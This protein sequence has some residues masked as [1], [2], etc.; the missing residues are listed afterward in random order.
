MHSNPRHNPYITFNY[1]V[2]HNVVVCYN[3]KAYYSF[4]DE[5]LI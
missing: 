4:A 2:E 1:L 5:G 3:G